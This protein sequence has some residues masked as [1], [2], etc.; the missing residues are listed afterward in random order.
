MA[1]AGVAS[2]SMMRKKV[3]LGDAPSISAASSSSFGMVSMYPLRFQIANGKSDES[4]ANPT[5]ISELRTLKSP[6]T[7]RFSST[8]SGASVA[9]VGRINTAS[10]ASISA[11]RPRKR[12][13]EKA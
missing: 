2:G 13:R 7:M 1:S 8:N 3:W 5:P 9:T 6:I 12:K 4:S 11:C 10:T